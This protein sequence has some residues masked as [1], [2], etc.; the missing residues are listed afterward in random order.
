MSIPNHVCNLI[1]YAVH[2]LTIFFKS[3]KLFFFDLSSLFL[4]TTAISI[5]KISIWNFVKPNK[6][7]KNHY[8]M[9]NLIWGLDVIERQIIKDSPFL[10]P[11]SENPNV[12]SVTERNDA[13]HLLNN[14]FFVPRR[15]IIKF[16]KMIFDIFSTASS[17]WG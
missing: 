2:V 6:I 4:L 1:S 8:S 17:I 15:T 13:Y 16:R 5:F 9:H 7:V 12:L 10:F 14:S 11:N 3:T